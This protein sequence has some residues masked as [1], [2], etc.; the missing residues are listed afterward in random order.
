M[1]TDEGTKELDVEGATKIIFRIKSSAAR[2]FKAQAARQGITMQSVL[3]K[4]VE[5]FLGKTATAAATEG[6]AYSRK[7]SPEG[8]AGHKRAQAARRKPEP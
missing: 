6:E 3:Q 8:Y 5:A 4:A 2:E 7:E 1:V